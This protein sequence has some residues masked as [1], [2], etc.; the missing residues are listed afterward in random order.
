[1][2]RY[3]DLGKEPQRSYSSYSNYSSYS[4]YRSYSS[5]SNCNNYNKRS[6]HSRGST[7]TEEKELMILVEINGEKNT[8]TVYLYPEEVI[9]ER[10]SE[11]LNIPRPRIEE[12]YAV[13]R[14]RVIC[15]G[16]TAN[17]NNLQEGDSI[18][19]KGKLRGG[20]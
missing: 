14:G 16:E 9:E 11:V 5:Y 19:L 8:R 13:S 1:M 7:R 15:L 18:H 4:S 6:S 12:M 3:T 2:P 10:I 20:S 17:Y